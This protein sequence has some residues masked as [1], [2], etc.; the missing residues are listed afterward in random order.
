MSSLA[1]TDRQTLARCGADCRHTGVVRLVSSLFLTFPRAGPDRTAA[2]SP[3]LRAV[4]D[5]FE[6]G[7][8]RAVSADNNYEVSEV[9]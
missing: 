2:L 9:C 7:F 6:A 5:L 3:L 1:E 8:L 4:R